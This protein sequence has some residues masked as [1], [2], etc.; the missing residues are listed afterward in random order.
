[1][2]TKMNKIFT[3]LLLALILVFASG[4]DASSKAGEKAYDYLKIIDQNHTQRVAGSV[5][6]EN[7]ATYIKVELEK[8]GYQ[9]NIE[10]FSFTRSS[11][12]YDSQNVVAIKK[13]KS[14]KQIIIGAH[15]DSVRTNGAG[16]NGSGVS[17]ILE[18]AEKF[19]NKDSDYTLVF[20]FFGSEEVGLQGSKAY[21]NQMSEKEKQDTV[22]MI[23]LDSVLAGTYPYAY[24]GKVEAGKVVDTWAVDQAMQL[25]NEKNLGLHLNDTDLNFDYPSPTTGNWS[26]HASFKNEGI[27]YLYLEAANWELPDNPAK[28]ENG[29]SGAYETEIGTVMH[30][31]ARDNLAFI[32]NQWPGR[33]QKNLSTYVM[34]LEDYLLRANPAGLKKLP[35]PATKT[36]KKGNKTYYYKLNKNDAYDHIKTVVTN[37]NVVVVY[38]YSNN[39]KKALVSVVKEVKKN[40][41]VVFKQVKT[42]NKK[43]KVTKNYHYKINNK[44]KLI[45]TYKQNKTYSSKNV[46]KT[47]IIIKKNLNNKVTYKSVLTYSKKGYKQ[48]KVVS[49]YKN[50]LTKKITY[51]YNKKGQLKSNKNGK[52]TKNTKKYNKNGKVNSWQNQNYNKKGKLI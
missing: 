24:G 30:N 14:D 3:A 12:N 6:E 38:N 40:N 45:N 18:I 27:T 20:V 8:F 17:V 35:L 33:A 37:G 16:D 26:D 10:D 32:E 39:G 15:Y 11:T 31:A 41:K 50:K 48:K 43:G 29:S 47:N 1:M 44:G 22:L 4:I 5:A 2:K 19:V 13:G 9:A 28:P 7:M 21:V 36:T 34:L 42:Y 46:I 51:K 23:N 52:A 25:S 49:Y